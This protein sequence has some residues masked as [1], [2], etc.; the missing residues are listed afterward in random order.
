[1]GLREPA[2]ENA[3]TLATAMNVNNKFLCLTVRSF[4][5]SA[6]IYETVAG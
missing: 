5:F 1:M 2:Q 3:D 6:S 4:I